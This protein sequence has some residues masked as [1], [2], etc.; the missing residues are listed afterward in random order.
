MSYGHDEYF[1]QVCKDYLPEEALY[2]LRFHSC[3]AFHTED[4]YHWF[5]T[6]H[7][8]EMLKW[9][10]IFNQYDLYSKDEAEPD[11]EALKPFYQELINE[12]FPAKIKW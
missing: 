9:V 7:D 10:K 1:Y 4:Q 3:Y 6:E 12:F 8:H 2:I 5:M 11:V